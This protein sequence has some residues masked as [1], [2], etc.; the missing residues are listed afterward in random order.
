VTRAARRRP[1]PA[2]PAPST[3]RSRRHRQRKK[4]MAEDDDELVVRPMALPRKRATKYL[5]KRE[6]EVANDDE[7]FAALEPVIQFMLNY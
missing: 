5:R 2:N 6:I 7:L 3:L 4:V 1:D